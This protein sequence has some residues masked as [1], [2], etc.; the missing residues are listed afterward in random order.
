MVSIHGP[1]GF[2]VVR[3]MGPAQSLFATSLPFVHGSMS[4]GFTVRT[5]LTALFIRTILTI[6]SAPSVFTIATRLW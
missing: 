6:L 1:L 5:I 3:R 2:S 4:L